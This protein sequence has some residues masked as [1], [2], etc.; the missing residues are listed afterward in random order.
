[1]SKLTSQCEDAMIIDV[2]DI[3]VDA[4]DA[5]DINDEVCLVAAARTDRK[6]GGLTKPSLCVFTAEGLGRLCVSIMYTVYRDYCAGPDSSIN[7]GE[8]TDGKRIPSDF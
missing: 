3:A 6:Q 2:V 4:D 7:S 5:S 1:M 8:K